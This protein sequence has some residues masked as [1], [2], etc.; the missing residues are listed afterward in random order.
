[1]AWKERDKNIAT[2]KVK[3]AKICFERNVKRLPQSTPLLISKCQFQVLTDEKKWRNKNIVDTDKTPE[4]VNAKKLTN[5]INAVF[6]VCRNYNNAG[7]DCTDNYN[8]CDYRRHNYDASDNGFD[9]HNFS[10]YGR[11]NDD[12]SYRAYHYYNT[13]YHSRY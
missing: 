3:S 8:S 1:M 9:N 4:S 7:H 5:A 13:C 2:L 10:D 12:A 6:T 11:N